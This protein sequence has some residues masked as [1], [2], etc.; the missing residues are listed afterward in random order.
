VS[1]KKI[2]YAN[3]ILTK[4]TLYSFNIKLIIISNM[5]RVI[6]NDDIKNK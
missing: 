4:A 6:D 2:M 1:L 5:P 3:T